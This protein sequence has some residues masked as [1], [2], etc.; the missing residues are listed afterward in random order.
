MNFEELIQ[1]P[2]SSILDF[3][4]ELYDFSNDPENSNSKFIKDVISFCNTVRQEKSY[5][6]F[7]IGETTNGNIKLN[8]LSQNIDDSILQQKIKD[9]VFP[10]PIFSY[11]TLQYQ[12]KTFGVMEF[13][14]NKYE[15]PI[16]PSVKMKGLEVG[17][18]YFRN[19][20]SN[21]EANGMDVIRIN[22]WLR[23]LPG[24]ININLTDETTFLLKRITLNDE[25]LSVILNDCRNLAK[26]YSLLDLETFTAE[27]IKGLNSTESENYSYRIGKVIISIN[28]ISINPYSFVT[29]DI[30][31]KEIEKDKDFHEYKLFFNHSIVKLE[32]ILDRFSEKKNTTFATLQMSSK[33]I[34]GNGDYKVNVYIFEDT[35]LNVYSNIKQKT[36]DQLMNI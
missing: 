10:R 17:K 5:I 32:E 31:R 30:V 36:I 18:V 11:S 28:E 6:V 12:G 33:H 23:S 22:D 25:K 24:L 9:K 3:K 27:Q 26:K 29:A 13:P 4:N 14:I 16:M 15:S 1:N 20:T 19:G 34:F 35:L 2:E 7:G 21:T 8:G